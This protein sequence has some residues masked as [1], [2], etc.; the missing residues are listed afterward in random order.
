MCAMGKPM[1][2]AK[3]ITPRFSRHFAFF[4]IDEF[5]DETLQTIFS[6]IMLWHLDTR[7]VSSIYYSCTLIHYL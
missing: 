5:D 2:G 4:C 7:F 1:P 3:I 6:R